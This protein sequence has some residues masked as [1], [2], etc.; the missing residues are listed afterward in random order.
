MISKKPS[1][2]DAEYRLLAD[3]R[4]ALRGF[5]A[6]SK[7]ASKR[8]GLAPQQYQALL[9]LRARREREMTIGDL[10]EELFIRPHTAVELVDRLE[11]AGL[12]I[13]RSAA[14]GRSVVLDLTDS[15]EAVLAS[16]AD[17]H[18]AELRRY[19]PAIR[20]LLSDQDDDHSDG[21]RTRGPR[22]A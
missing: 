13:R 12:T 4:F 3:F 9:A 6:F 5:F 10:A 8:A 1:L 15:A 21:R 18:L 7:A 16:L 2:S 17:A 19:A 14:S 22:T 11:V 20:T